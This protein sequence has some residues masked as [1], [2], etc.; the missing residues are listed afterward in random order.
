MASAMLLTNASG[1][2]ARGVIAR[3]AQ[4]RASGAVRVQRQIA[5]IVRAE[6]SGD[7]KATTAGSNEPLYADEIKVRALYT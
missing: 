7:E 6:P 2:A 5:L 1:I 4:Q 3:P